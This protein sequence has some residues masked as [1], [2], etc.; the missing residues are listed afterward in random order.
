MISPH[1]NTATSRLNDKELHG[2]SDSLSPSEGERVGVSGGRGTGVPP[3]AS[4]WSSFPK[5]DP[6]DAMNTENDGEEISVTKVNIGEP[7]TTLPT[8]FHK[9]FSAFKSFAPHL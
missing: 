3:H 9:G 8:P 2:C 6:R 7:R 5:F 4:L 1:C